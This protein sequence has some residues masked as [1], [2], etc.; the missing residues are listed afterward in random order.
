MAFNSE[1]I[2]NK[3]SERQ[4]NREQRNRVKN[5]GSSLSPS[6][7]RLWDFEG[8]LKVSETLLSKI[9]CFPYTS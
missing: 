4:Y 2:N 6:T 9:Y 5:S 7:C 3:M 1:N 8:V